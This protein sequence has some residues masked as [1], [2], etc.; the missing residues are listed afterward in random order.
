MGLKQISYT[1]GWFITVYIKGLVVK[2]L[3]YTNNF[4][5]V[6]LIKTATM[7]LIFLFQCEFAENM[8]KINYF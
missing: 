7:I 3:L 4:P 5:Y 6:F 8:V 1:L 2:K